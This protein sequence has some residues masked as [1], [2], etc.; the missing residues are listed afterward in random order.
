MAER[1]N[2]ETLSSDPTDTDASTENERLMAQLKGEQRTN[3][4][5]RKQAAGIIKAEEVAE[6]LDVMGQSM[7]ALTKVVDALA[8]DEETTNTLAK[9]RES[10]S[11]ANEEIAAESKVL[12]DIQALEL[13]SGVSMDD[14]PRAAAQAEAG[15]LSRALEELQS[16]VSAKAAEE[17]SELDQQRNR[18]ESSR[19][20]DK[21]SSTMSVSSE[22]MTTEDGIKSAYDKALAEGK[23]GSDLQPFVDAMVNLKG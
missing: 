7:D 22:N 8:G 19:K 3:A 12:T 2:E 16:E 5:L 15:N 1:A 10:V 13:D 6:K 23:S 11:K 21:G 9:L 18:Q 14:V 17:D 4:R 20:V